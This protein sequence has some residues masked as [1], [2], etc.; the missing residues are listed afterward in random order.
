[1]TAI[2]GLAFLPHRPRHTYNL[3]RCFRLPWP[4]GI[5]M[6]AAAVLSGATCCS[7]RCRGRKGK[8]LRLPDPATGSLERKQILSLA[9]CRF[10]FLSLFPVSNVFTLKANWQESKA[11]SPRQIR[12]LHHRLA[13]I[14]HG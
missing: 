3:T 5:P 12:A 10:D 9:A 2:D 11:A 8:R 4:A 1:M 14:R 13:D 7:P 6:A